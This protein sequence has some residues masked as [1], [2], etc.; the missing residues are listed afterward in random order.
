MVCDK[1]LFIVLLILILVLS[2]ILLILRINISNVI[3]YNK[4]MVRGGNGELDRLLNEKQRI[5]NELNQLNQL[6]ID[7]D[8]RRELIHDLF[9]VYN[10]IIRCIKND[11]ISALYLSFGINNEYDKNKLIWE[12]IITELLNDEININNLNYSNPN[13]NYNYDINVDALIDHFITQISDKYLELKIPN[14]EEYM[15]KNNL[16]MAMLKLKLTPR[17]RGQDINLIYSLYFLI[18]GDIK[19]VEDLQMNNFIFKKRK[20]F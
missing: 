16:T 17:D 6:N 3:N 13:F 14:L 20:V 10:K 1:N 9:I 8:H 5:I 4:I 11:A 19:Q 2:I 18:F 15:K 12:K 7:Q